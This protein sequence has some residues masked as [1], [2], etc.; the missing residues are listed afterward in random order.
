VKHIVPSALARK[1]G[2]KTEAKEN[3]WTRVQ[4]K[5]KKKRF[6]TIYILLVQHI[7]SSSWPECKVAV[8][9]ARQDG[10][11]PISRFGRIVARSELF[12]IGCV[13]FYNEHVKG[14]CEGSG[15]LIPLA[16]NLLVVPLYKLLVI[17]LDLHSY[18]GDGIMR[19]TVEFHPFTE[20]KQMTRLISKSGAEIEVTISL[21][22]YF[23]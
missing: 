10:E 2:R 21:T 15:D 8:T 1:Q 17:E 20:G 12:D 16:R 9:L 11:D 19:E 14:I 13:L 18:Y 22:Q 7:T 6:Q 3:S 5:Q 4:V 23:R